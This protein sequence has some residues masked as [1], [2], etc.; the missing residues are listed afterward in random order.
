MSA[1]PWNPVT[2]L[3]VVGAVLAFPVGGWPSLLGVLFGLT[4]ASSWFRQLGKRTASVARKAE[5]E[6]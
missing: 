6:H 3:L 2:L 4:A 5:K 1:K